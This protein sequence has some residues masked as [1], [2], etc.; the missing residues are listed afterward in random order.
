MASR[1]ERDADER[2][3]PDEQHGVHLLALLL[4][5]PVFSLFAPRL[6]AALGLPL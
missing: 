2:E 6:N 3:K 5:L 4:L 1:P